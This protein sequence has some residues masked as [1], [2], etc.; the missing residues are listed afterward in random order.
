MGNDALDQ[1]RFPSKI[2]MNL[3]NFL[4][5]QTDTDSVA[6]WLDQCSQ[7]VIRRH[8]EV[9]YFTTVKS[10]HHVL[11]FSILADALC[12]KGKCYCGGLF[13]LFLCSL[14]HLLGSKSPPMRLIFLIL[15][16][17]LI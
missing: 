16:T 9:L 15:E 6:L 12:H 2:A 8:S 17:I 5:L 11:T 3:T 1:H 13:K 10:N 14:V 4:S 7:K